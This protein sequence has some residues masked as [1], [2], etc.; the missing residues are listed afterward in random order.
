MKVQQ[1]TGRGPGGTAGGHGCRHCQR[2][3]KTGEYFVQY[4]M[5]NNPITDRYFTLHVRCM[6]ELV[7]DVPEDVDRAREG[8]D[9]LREKILVTGNL[10]PN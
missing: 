8:F 1:Q 2:S 10:F 5:P 3:I 6:R 9:A 4:H 7:A